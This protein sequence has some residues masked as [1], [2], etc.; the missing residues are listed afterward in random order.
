MW[1]Y[2]GRTCPNNNEQPEW[3]I[4]YSIMNLS[5]RRTRAYFRE[6][7]ILKLQDPDWDEATSAHDPVVSKYLNSEVPELSAFAS[8]Q[9]DA[10]PPPEVKPFT[11]FA[12]EKNVLEKRGNVAH[13]RRIA[14]RYAQVAD[15]YPRVLA[16]HFSGPQWDRTAF[17]NAFDGVRLWEEL[18][19]QNYVLLLID[20][21]TVM[22]EQQLRDVTRGLEAYQ[23][24][25]MECLAA[26][27]KATDSSDLDPQR[28]GEDIVLGEDAREILLRPTALFRCEGCG[29][30]PYAWPKINVH[31]QDKHPGESVWKTY[32]GREEGAAIAKKIL[33]ALVESG[34]G[35]EDRNT[36]QLDRLIQSGRVFCA[37]GDPRM[38]APDQGLNWAALVKHVSVHLTENACRTVRFA[39][40]ES[41][42]ERD[43]VWVD[44]H[45]LSSCIKH[46]P[47]GAD[48]AHAWKRV[49]ADPNACARINALLGQCPQN[50]RPVCCLCAALNTSDDWKEDSTLSL[51]E[52]AD[53]VVYHIQ[54]KHG[55][56]F[57]DKDVVF[58]E[59]SVLETA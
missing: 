24:S 21:D 46:L 11:Q 3:L 19:L 26:A 48:T 15:W 2:V 14:G 56:D 41:S 10:P 37:C 6:D 25:V 55:K 49:R 7:A 31:W 4:S 8:A 9:L 35:E 17:P 38:A 16:A 50:S 29:D 53:A 34:L 20:K 40:D 39:R 22:G 42:A 30:Y 52:S 58:W 36:K 23:K 45:D 33:A 44:D 51:P 59:K 13:A 1:D 57:E 18:V 47:D 28:N 32:R 43:P 12:V 54:A 5:P 27:V